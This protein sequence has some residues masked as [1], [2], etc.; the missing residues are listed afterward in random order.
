MIEGFLLGN[1]GAML[2][3]KLW[4]GQLPLYIHPR[5]SW[6]IGVTAVV[7]IVLGVVRLWGAGEAGPGGRGRWGLFALLAA[8]LLF[9]TLIPVKPVGSALI[10]PSQL[11][12]GGRDFGRSRAI[13]SADTREWSLFDWM[14]ARY[15]YAPDDARGKPVDVIGFVY[16]A[17]GAPE[18][19]F[20][21]VRFTVAC[22]VA[23]RRG[24]SL[25][26]TSAAAAT[27]PEDTWVRVT[28]V[29]TTRGTDE[30]AEFVVE[31]ATVEVVPQPADPYLYP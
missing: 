26:V 14:I 5:Y 8:P 23:D 20:Q 10:D 28:G 16:H 30:E 6:L 11:N 7:M 27:L 15:V 4:Y 13:V 22:C 9:G 3:G 19:E 24:V 25:P 18:G 31:D 2:L 17:P 29:I 1:I 21:V 12:A